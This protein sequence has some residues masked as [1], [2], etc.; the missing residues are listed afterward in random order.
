MAKTDFTR[1]SA[2]VERDISLQLEQ[3]D[4]SLDSSTNET[5]RKGQLIVGGIVSVVVFAAILG[6]DYFVPTPK[7]VTEVEPSVLSADP[8]I[9]ISSRDLGLIQLQLDRIDRQTSEI[10]STKTRVA[11]A[12]AIDSNLTTIESST[13]DI[14]AYLGVMEGGRAQ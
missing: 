14:R 9:A 3:I 1:T 12:M 11:P 13:K 6:F 7:E 10:R 4:R 8:T 5:E 2:Q